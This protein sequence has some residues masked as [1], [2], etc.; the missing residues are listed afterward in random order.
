[1]PT[2]CRPSPSPPARAPSL[3]LSVAPQRGRAVRAP[4]RRARRSRREPWPTTPACSS[5]NRFVLVL[6]GV[7]ST[8]DLPQHSPERSPQRSYIRTGRVRVP[9]SAQVG[10]RPLD[11]IPSR[12][13]PARPKTQ[14]HASPCFWGS[15]RRTSRPLGSLSNPR[16][17][18]APSERTG[19]TP[20][21]ELPRRLNTCSRLGC[22]GRWRRI[23]ERSVGGRR[24]PDRRAAV[25]RLRGQPHQRRVFV[26]GGSASHSRPPPRA[27][28]SRRGGVQARAP[29]RRSA[30]CRPREP[31][32]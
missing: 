9:C 10:L 15:G 30:S 19:S 11:F 2:P 6:G 23:D 26:A 14:G 17:L 32:P 12:L 5:K 27:G 21:T 20:A 29:A 3:R 1:M 7:R 28:A 13:N 8:V 4:T 16:C 18:F 31:L 22:I 24:C 25:R